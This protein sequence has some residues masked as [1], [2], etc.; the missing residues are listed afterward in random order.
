[1]KN[2]DMDEFKDV[3][4]IQRF[5]NYRNALRRLEEAG[6]IVN[7]AMSSPLNHESVQLLKEGLL[8]RFE[9]TQEL[10]WK[11]M[12]D[13]LEYQGAESIMGSRD[14]FRQ[15]LKLGLISDDRWL[16]SITD[17]NITSHAYD[18]SKAGVIYDNV[19]KV[20]L[21]LFLEFEQKMMV[22]VEDEF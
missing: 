8:Q 3:R 4:W 5:N 6:D 22:I 21:P 15:S 11:V 20:Y 10:A 16:N 7:V 9:F 19:R 17:R 13:Y 2:K 18:E 14:A 12:K 1:M